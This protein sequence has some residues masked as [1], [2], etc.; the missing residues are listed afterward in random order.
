[1]VATPIPTSTRFVA[2]ENTTVYYLPT[3]AAGTYIPTRTEINGG[4]NL[5]G[6]IVD[7]SGFSSKTNFIDTPK[8]TTRFQPK[9]ADTEVADDSSLTFA[10]DKAGVD[11]RTVLSRDDTGFIMICDGGDV[12]ANKA[13]VYPVEVASVTPVRAIS[14]TEFRVRVDFSITHPP[15]L[16]I[17]IPT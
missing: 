17:A 2:L 5:T 13:D 9:L 3:I 10:G 6:E 12:A 11:V 14:G 8:L 4:T 7:W 15:A 16:H 1:M